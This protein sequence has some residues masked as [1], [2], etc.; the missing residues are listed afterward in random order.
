MLASWYF[1]SGRHVS[2]L[3]LCKRCSDILGKRRLVLRLECDSF[4]RLGALVKHITGGHLE[5]KSTFQPMNINFGL[6][7]P[8]D[9]G[10]VQ[11]KDP[12]TG[13]R[14]RGMDKG[15]AKKRAQAARALAD[16]DSWLARQVEAI[17]A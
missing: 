16:V 12:T 15:R 4:G 6:F 2:F 9:P 7:P 8:A 1:I 5:G 14:L 17:P 11:T 13:K 10:S 3:P